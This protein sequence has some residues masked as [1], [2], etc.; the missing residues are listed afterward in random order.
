[1]KR[2]SKTLER[3]AHS[4]PVQRPTPKVPL[5]QRENSVAAVVAVAAVAVVAVVVAVASTAFRSAQKWTSPWNADVIWSPFLLLL[6]LLLLLL[7]GS[8]FFSRLV[9]P[10]LIGGGTKNRARRP[11]FATKTAATKSEATVRQ[12]KKKH[13][14]KM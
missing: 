6:L 4:A 9:L 2:R 8:A 11:H 14:T 10:S 3:F 7:F 1:M 12:Q 5:L 13:E